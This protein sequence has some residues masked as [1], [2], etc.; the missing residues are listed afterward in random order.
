MT[1]FPIAGEGW[2]FILPAFALVVLC[3]VLHLRAAAGVALVL[4]LFVT[5]FFRDPVR[6][7]PADPETLVSP[8]DGRVVEILPLADGG[9]QISIFLSIFNVHVNRSPVAG[10]VVDVSRRPGK[11][12]A[13]WKHEA[14]SDNFQNSVTVRTPRGDVRFVQITGL[15]ARRIVCHLE[16][17]ALVARGERYGLIRFGSRVDLF[18]PP[19]AELAV[20]VGDRV[21]GGSDVIARWRIAL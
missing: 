14:S 10:E 3:A 12:L 8:A 11:F 9:A 16:T 6:A 19:A 18:L 7:I 2:P 17:G 5:W 13:A 4:A 15:I 21:H 20:R 1:R